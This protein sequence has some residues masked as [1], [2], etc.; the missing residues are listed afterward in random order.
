M[1]RA[2]LQAAL[3]LVVFV[4][5]VPTP[6]AAGGGGGACGGGFGETQELV[7]VDSCFSFGTT[8][9]APGDVEVVNEGAI[10]HNVT[11][12]DGSFTTG[13][14]A[15]GGRSVIALPEAGI[16]RIYCTLHGS[17][18]GAGMSGVL[19]AGN[20]TAATTGGGPTA[21]LLGAGL[22]AS[23]SLATAITARTTARSPA[24]A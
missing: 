24:V 20:P 6:A 22:I 10:G 4:V 2:L 3:L 5:L 8:F 11:A 19:I 1:R 13:N 15:P 21:A 9:L 14:V 23:L 16:Y 17:P 7:L 18:D 12:A